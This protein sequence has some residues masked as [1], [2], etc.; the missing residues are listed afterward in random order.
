VSRLADEYREEMASV[1]QATRPEEEWAR[2][3]VETE[4]SAPVHQHDDYS[5]AGMYDLV[6]RY[7][8]RRLAPAGSDH[9]G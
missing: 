1:P 8:G 3:M 9:S 6:I 2:R 7:A 5:A 4:L